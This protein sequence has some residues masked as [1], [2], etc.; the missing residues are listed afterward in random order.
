MITSLYKV[1]SEFIDARGA[2]GVP[3]DKKLPRMD[4]VSPWLFTNLHKTTSKQH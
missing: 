4:R 3:D 2:L 1:F